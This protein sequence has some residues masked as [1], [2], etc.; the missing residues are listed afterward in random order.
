[1]LSLGA[2]S[3]AAPWALAALIA[4]PA[5]WWLL[6]LTPPAPFRMV[7]PPLRILA[8]LVTPEETSAKS[9]L[10]LILLRLLLATV[11]ILA[12]A[13]PVMNAG[14]EIQG[15]GPLLIAVDN[16]WAAARDWPARQTALAG[17]LDQAGREGRTVALVTTAARPA[18]AAAEDIS[19]TSADT[20]RSRAEA[21]KPQP[22]TTDHE[23][24]LARIRQAPALTATP[25]GEVIWLSDGLSDAATATWIAGLRDIAP[26]RVLRDPPG[27]PIA[28]LLPPENGTSG[29]RAAAERASP[30]GLANLWL[31]AYAADGTLLARQPLEFTDGSTDAET[32]IDLPAELRNRLVRLDERWRRRP[33]GLV[34][35]S[36][37]PDA[38]PLLSE[39][40]YV[41]RALEP[42]TEIRRGT[43]DSL[44]ERQ[45][46]VLVVADASPLTEGDGEILGRWV[47]NG[48]IL[49]RFAG[50]VL[51]EAAGN[52]ALESLLPVPLRP[53]GRTLGGALSWSRPA[54]LAPFAPESPFAGLT[55]PGDVT[56]SAQVLAQ[57][58]LDLAERTWVR[59]ADGTPLITAAPRGNGWTILV[60]TSANAAWSD[61]AISGLFVE[62][63][64]RI[65]GLSQGTA[66][67]N[68][69]ATLAPL[70]I[71]DGFG[72]LGAPPPSAIGI[73]ATDFPSTLAGPDHP[74]GFYGR[75]EARRALNLAPS[76][77]TLQ[78]LTTLA[79]GVT[80]EVYGRE[81]EIAF[82]PW[83]M[84]LAMVLFLID[85]LAAMILRGLLRPR[86]VAAAAVVL[87]A[88][89]P[90]GGRVEAQALENLGGDAFA[91][92]AAVTT[93]LAYVITGDDGIDSTSRAGLMGLSVIVNR[94]TAAELGDP[95]GVDIEADDLLF[96]PFVYW[97]LVDGAVP[98]P[99]AAVRI[100]DYLSGGGVILFDSRDPN[101][102]VALDTMRT[103][104]DRLQ[105]PP[106]SPVPQ[107]HVLGR[108]YYL[109][110]DFP[111]RW[112]GSTLWI[113]RAG[114]R[115]N[116]GVS[117][118][119][120]GS[121][122]WAGAWAMDAAQRPLYA[123]VPG[124]ERQREMAYRFGINLVMYTLTGNYKGDQ[125]HLPAILERLGL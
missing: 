45:L 97:P 58:A 66:T 53:G 27:Q 106:L 64:Q 123:V 29:L 19:L 26:L 17:L 79:P 30:Q 21:L 44:L 125:V 89:A 46:A 39:F 103:L 116:D 96:F 36:R 12:L 72:V 38:Q 33:V 102:A 61:L 107:E 9:P 4:L 25:P 23:A 54:K 111:G 5:I 76:L 93:R 55:V 20:A 118:V 114:E 49:L 3:F 119:I 81:R 99:E 59:L 24:A 70:E 48:G 68:E 77:P 34:T 84:G 32:T 91:L 120:A 7:F 16:G 67:G 28:R 43:V 15:A 69:T 63:L 62:M 110:R 122:D 100:R 117:P 80:T 40:F 104:A 108:S 109:L 65:V 90:A 82:R 51:A 47:E 85:L 74:P 75:G 11:L 50:P 22:W 57:P 41:E 95:V 37:D 8:R 13:S 105:I 10:W 73:D 113:E 98:S 1:M 31:R 60:H 71:L 94:R 121:N 78:A 18:S 112:T 124:G 56:V 42:F 6:R 83:L 87:I 115:I 88:L 14:R 52:P 101:G 35:G 86:Q 92:E 2:L